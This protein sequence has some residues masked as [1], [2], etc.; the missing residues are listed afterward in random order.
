[1]NKF[2]EKYYRYQRNGWRTAG[3][4]LETTEQGVH[5]EL[6][7]MTSQCSH[8]QRRGLPTQVPTLHRVGGDPGGGGRL[9]TETSGGEREKEDQKRQHFTPENKILYRIS[10]GLFKFYQ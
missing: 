9:L 7:K 10:K 8:R 5:H 3:E 2:Y 4:P 1:M 6:P